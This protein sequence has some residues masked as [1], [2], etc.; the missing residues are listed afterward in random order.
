MVPLTAS[1]MAWVT[2]FSP[3]RRDVVYGIGIR[4]GVPPIY[5]RF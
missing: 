2:F 1:S 5:S 3:R 4:S